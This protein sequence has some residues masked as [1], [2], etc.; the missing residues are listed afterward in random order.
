MIL[1]CRAKQS[2]KPALLDGQARQP[3]PNSTAPRQPRMLGR[4]HQFYWY[5]RRRS[6]TVPYWTWILG[7]L[8]LLTLMCFLEGAAHEQKHAYHST[9]CLP[10]PQHYLYFSATRAVRLLQPCGT[11]LEAWSANE[12]PQRFGLSHAKQSHR[13]GCKRDA[14]AGAA[15]G[16]RT[17]RARPLRC[18]RAPARRVLASNA[19]RP[20]PPRT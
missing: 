20:P 17:H 5:R 13:C 1:P 18:T 9:P 8:I 14:G 16:R 7:R 19:Y 11:P 4:V 3:K 12:A 10:A 6:G 15:R 2:R